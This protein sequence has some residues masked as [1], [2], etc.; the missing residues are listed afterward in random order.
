MAV[1]YIFKAR[2]CFNVFKR[3]YVKQ[4]R[5]TAWLSGGKRHCSGGAALFV[6]ILLTKVPCCWLSSSAET[7]SV[8]GVAA[9]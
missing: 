4:P 7:A 5:H 8:V 3:V 2:I 9:V 6:L 1:S